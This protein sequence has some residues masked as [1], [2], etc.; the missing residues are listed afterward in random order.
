M[1]EA[2]RWL[3]ERGAFKPRGV[4]WESFAPGSTNRLW[5]GRGPLG[6]WLLKWYRRPLPGVHPEP[7][8]GRF[9]WERGFRGVPEF[10]ARLDR[11]GAEGVE[12]VAYV[13]RWVSGRAAWDVAVEAFRAGACLERWA[14]GLGR[15]VGALHATL[16]N[17]EVAPE[18][19]F[20]TV[21]YSVERHG[22]WVARV[23]SVCG[24][25]ADALRS[26]PP[27]MPAVELEEARALWI[28]GELR[29]RERLDA[30]GSLCVSAACSR[31]HGDLH[32]G[33][34]LQGGGN[35]GSTL[36]G[37]VSECWVVDF[38]GEPLR[39]LAERREPGLPLRDVAGMWRSFAYAAATAGVT[40]E[41][42]VRPRQAFLEGWAERMPLPT[43]D[44]RGLFDALVWE[45]AV[46]EALYEIE[47]R[48]GW[49]W[50]PLR[51]LA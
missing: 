30:L 31:I 38:E 26:P 1:K 46:Y 10:G 7:E 50:I 15:C 11:A 18:Q 4:R 9:L 35:G 41:K 47:H 39:P 20:K 8:I 3:V 5:R 29:W 34:I 17:L 44:W 12:T 13:Q 43:G 19:L 27:G 32:L 2:G 6:D 49:F 23:R 36:S 25:L 45:K 21:Q 14:L 28:G 24:R 40:A 16:S 33:Q 48:P 51:A 37:E 22:N 42:T